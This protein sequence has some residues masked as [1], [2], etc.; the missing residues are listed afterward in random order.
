[1][2]EPIDVTKITTSRIQM[3]YGK[4]ETKTTKECEIYQNHLNEYRHDTKQTF[5]DSKLNDDALISATR[6]RLWEDYF[7]FTTLPIS[8]PFIISVHG[9]FAVSFNRRSLWSAADNKDLAA[10]ALASL[11]VSWN[12]Y[13]FEIVLP[14]ALAKFLRKFCKDLL[15]NVVE[16]PN[17][18]DRVF[19]GPP[20][21]YD[22]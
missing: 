19:K 16:N 11:K 17:F 5:S 20:S 2:S 21:L 4:K 8:M 10:D 9:Y 14:K 15:Q 22:I 12:R 18:E 3:D 6:I 13:L 7:A 1:M